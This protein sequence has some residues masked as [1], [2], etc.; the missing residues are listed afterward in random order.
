M[1]LFIGRDGL[2]ARMEDCNHCLKLQCEEL[3]LGG[4]ICSLFLN[5]MD[6]QV[7]TPVSNKSMWAAAASSLDLPMR[8]TMIFARQIWR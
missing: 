3:F 4:I 8:I 2:V 1:D 5:P 6:A 7:S